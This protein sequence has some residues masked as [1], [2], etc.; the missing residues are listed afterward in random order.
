[1]FDTILAKSPSIIYRPGGVPGGLVVTT[2]DQVQAFIAFRQGTVILYVDDSIVS[3]A[4][5]PGASG[6]TECFGRLVLNAWAGDSDAFSVLQIEDG[7]TLQNLAEIDVVEVRC[8]CQS[9]TPSLA[10]TLTPNGGF[11]RINEIGKLSNATTATQPAVVLTGN[12][13][14]FLTL[15][16]SFLSL[17]NPAVPL[18]SVAAGSALEFDAYDGS[19]VPDG[20]AT[21]TGTVE[22]VYDNATASFFATPGVAPLLPGVGTYAPSNVDSVWE[23]K[24]LDPVTMGA[25]AL[26]NVPVFDGTKW[27]AGSVPSGSITG[28][29]NTG[30]YFNAAGVLTETPTFI[31]AIDATGFF[32]IGATTSDN[33]SSAR[34]QNSSIIAN[35]SQF[36]SN[37]YGNNAGT[38][39]LSTFKSRGAT[40]GSIV[41]LLAG[42]PISRWTTVGVAPDNASIPLSS[43]VTIQVPTNFVPAGQ[44][45][46]PSELEVQLVPLAGPI[47]GQR[48]SFKISSEGE[49]Q[50][51]R[52]VRAGG[53]STLPTNLTT[54]T[55]WSSDAVNPNGAVVGSPGDLFSDTAG[56]AGGVLWIKES[57]VATN[58]GW[59]PAGS[60]VAGLVSTIDFAIGT[61]ATTTSATLLST[62]A[63]VLRADVTITTPY[64]PGATIE[65][66]QAGSLNLFQD[67]PDNVPTV[68]D[69]YSAPQRTAAVTATGVVATIGG[70]PAAG[71]GFVTVQY[72]VPNP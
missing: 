66:G 39:G 45:W 6:V 4:L 28:T 56:S 18:F 10:W 22:L 21:G 65:V 29:P 11:L 5:V 24:L 7:A 25:P 19:V 60:T 27:I 17:H 15:N 57:G 32:L 1:M 30:A 8:N 31:T 2:W 54:G 14:L 63:I 51:L 61:A 52:G 41:G 12:K 58:T 70:A 13:D 48:V 69:F 9:G 44:N 55:L 71:A 72:A 34:V 20:F 3:P 37:Q 33:G 16:N 42:D 53:P 40:I 50:T 46:L 36:R 35:G 47:N 64:S 62:G 43:F 23:T 26:N 49:T 67:T 59:V 38:P 68:A